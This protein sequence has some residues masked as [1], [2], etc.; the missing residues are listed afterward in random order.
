MPR[1]SKAT[2][3]KIYPSPLEVEAV[4]VFPASGGKG[5]PVNGQSHRADNGAADNV[6]V[7]HVRYVCALMFLC[8]RCR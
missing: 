3:L 2:N 7:E 4:Q 5:S 6:R 1:L 8:R